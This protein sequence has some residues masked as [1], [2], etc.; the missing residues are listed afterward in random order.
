MMPAHSAK[1][2]GPLTAVVLIS[3]IW[4]LLDPV[5]VCG[6]WKAGVIGAEEA[7]TP[8]SFWRHTE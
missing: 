7:I 2:T 8:R 1:Q 5:A 6:G 4:T 3:T